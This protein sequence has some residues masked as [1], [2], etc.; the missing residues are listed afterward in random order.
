MIKQKLFVMI[1]PMIKH[2]QQC[3]ESAGNE[4]LISLAL[5]LVAGAGATTGTAAAP[6][7]LK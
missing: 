6:A 7:H 4:T 5:W 2:L 3:T 1:W